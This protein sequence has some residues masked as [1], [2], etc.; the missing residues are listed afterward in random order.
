MRIAAELRDV[1]RAYAALIGLVRAA[2]GQLHPGLCLHQEGRAL[3]ATVDRQALAAAEAPL[4]LVPEPLLVPV[5][6]LHWRAASRLEPTT[7]LERLSPLQRQVLDQMLELYALTGKLADLPLRLPA[8]ALAPGSALALRLRTGHPPWEPGTLSPAEAFLR[9]RTLGYPAAPLVADAAGPARTP[10][11]MPLVDV[12]NHHPDGARFKTRP[13]GVRVDPWPCGDGGECY[14]SYG[15]KDAMTLLL[16]YGYVAR[17]PRFL[18][19]VACELPVPGLGRLVIQGQHHRPHMDLPALEVLADGLSISHINLDAARPLRARAILRVLVAGLHPKLAGAELDS[20]AQA[21]W[22]AVLHANRGYY[23]DLLAL[24][25]AEP[26][27]PVTAMIAEVARH[28]LG[29]LE[30]IGQAAS[31]HEQIPP[32]A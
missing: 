1:E 19:S 12:L 2:G 30:A 8:L 16:Q 32:A 3:W 7:G 4:I 15:Y 27:V 29:L 18:H 22:T 11:L 9:T 13:S 31:G 6:D 14:A 21:A 26:E 20:L 23:Q 25:T 28:Q 5:A 10:V 17:E 24:S